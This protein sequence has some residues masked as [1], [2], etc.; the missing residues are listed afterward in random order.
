MPSDYLISIPWEW[1]PW[2]WTCPSSWVWE[3]WVRHPPQGQLL[4]PLLQSPT[5]SPLH[6]E[7]WSWIGCILTGNEILYAIKHESMV[8]FVSRHY[9]RVVN[10]SLVVC[11]SEYLS[12]RSVHDKSLKRH[13]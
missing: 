4:R 5:N 2:T 12:L 6:P 9:M 11:L 3:L 10:G 7:I 8:S 13:A 1:Q